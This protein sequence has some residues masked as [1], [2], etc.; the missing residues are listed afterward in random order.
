MEWK[1]VGVIYGA[2]LVGRGLVDAFGGVDR[3]FGKA[4]APIEQRPSTWLAVAGAIGL[5]LF[6]RYF[7]VGRTI[8]TALIVIGGQFFTK[9]YEIAR[10]FI[11]PKATQAG[12]GFRPVE[13]RVVPAPVQVP[14]PVPAPVTVKPA[15]V[16]RGEI[17]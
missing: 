4:V 13:V 8:E 2:Q 12:L 14:T 1:E 5:P 17:Y 16:A 7:R 15:P 6:T 9:V 10:E 3:H 11:A